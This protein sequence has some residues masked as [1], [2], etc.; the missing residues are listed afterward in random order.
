MIKEGNDHFEVTKHEPKVDFCEKKYV[1]DAVKAPNATRD[2]VFEASAKCPPYV[3][4]DD[5][6]EGVRQ[7]EQADDAEMAR[8]AAKG[9]PVARMNTGIDGGMNKVFAAALPN[10]DTG[11]SEGG[12]GQS[13]S[14]VR[15]RL[16]GTIPMDHVNPPHSPSESL[17]AGA[18]EEPKIAAPAPTA[19]ATRVASA[20]PAEQSGGFFS[21]L[22]RKVGLGGAAADT[23]ASAPPPPVP[24]KPKAE[25]RRSAPRSA[26]PGETKQAAAKPALKPSV[27][28]HSSTAAAAPAPA[29]QNSVVAGAQPIM[30][31]NSFD[32]RFSATK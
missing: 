4:P 1:F 7:K 9:T 28:D 14:L 23:T 11:L 30:P 24:T 6:A 16:P 13:L 18:P 26:K 10:G 31:A 29:A 2:P 12:Q 21:N 32:N 20:A 5:I 17:L 15:E 25:A 19:P 3:I 8:L 22:A 27:T